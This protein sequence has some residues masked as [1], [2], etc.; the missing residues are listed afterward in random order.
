MT[1]KL[2]STWDFCPNGF[3]GLFVVC[4]QYLTLALSLNK[5]G[6]SLVYDTD[7]SLEYVFTGVSRAAGR[8][9]LILRTSSNF[10]STSSFS[11]DSF[12]L[13]QQQ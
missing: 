8:I 9:A 10:C 11:D 4:P 1:A 5:N 13:D 6:I 3:I 12:A 7:W 2:F